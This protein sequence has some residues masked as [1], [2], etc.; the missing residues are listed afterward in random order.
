MSEPTM[1]VPSIPAAAHVNAPPPPGF[2]L[3][4]T[5]AGAGPGTP[6][7]EAAVPIAT[8]QALLREARRR[9][10]AGAR[11]EGAG[12][13]LEVGQFNR[14]VGS[15]KGRQIGA[16]G[17]TYMKLAVAYRTRDGTHYHNTSTV[18]CEWYHIG[19]EECVIAKAAHDSVILRR[20]GFAPV[21]ENAIGMATPS[22][23]SKIA[24]GGL[25]VTELQLP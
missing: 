5:A 13:R 2:T 17:S 11:P 16:G 23:A 9:P 19:A 8:S 20:T 12:R 1:R 18:Q 7:A 10:A 21:P 24:A 15:R 14:R 3:V 4:H 6:S 22:M 25:P